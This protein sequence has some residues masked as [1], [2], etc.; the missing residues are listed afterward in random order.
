VD[1]ATV[2]LPAPATRRPRPEWTS[3]VDA[4]AAGTRALPTVGRVVRRFLLGD[5]IAIVLLLGGSLWVSREAAVREAIADARQR[6]DS[7]AVL[8]VEPA[9][10]D[11]LLE[12]DPAA[13]AAMDAVLRDRTPAVGM[14][15]V[16]IWSP[17]GRIVYSDEPRLIG[18]PYELS[19]DE[20]EALRDGRTRA[21][22]S[23][24]NRP[25]N[26]FERSEGR[27]LEVYRTIRTPTGRP[28]LL[29][30]YS[31]YDKA[32]ERQID[33][34]WSFAPITA[35]VL[36]G[37]FVVQLPLAR[38]MTSQL[39][40]VHREREML[41]ARALDTSTEERRR[42]AR[43][44]HDGI[45]QDVSAA[46]LL[47]AGAADQLRTGHGSAAEVTDTLADASVALR[48]SV[49]SLRSLLVE[50]Y[51]PNLARSGLAPALADLAARLR[52]RGIEVT[53]VLPDP[54][55]LPVATATLLFRTAQEALLN[56]VKHARAHRVE[57]AVRELPDRWM[58]TITDDGDGFDL[59][60]VRR[61]PRPGHLGLSLLTDLAAADGAALAIR[62]APGAGTSLRL[63][64][65]RR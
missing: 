32:T 25:E 11:G 44:L 58:L 57:V 2:G 55:D 14:L 41:Q 27:L 54:L 1:D 42:I 51:P 59:A 5:L 23:D 24:L 9:V 64:V 56:I 13:V 46:S 3:L 4:S 49:G 43:N 18:V 21:E 19:Q 8:L 7:L 22:L 29:E 12:G 6:T 48:E 62:T 20:Q 10:D 17:D 40:A 37:L 61:R 30:T 39:R 50:I 60:A 65:P 28:L 34:W 47:L 45:V 16:K 35:S 36:L 15:R 53:M 38:R 26:R 63:A 52:P 31:P 33:I